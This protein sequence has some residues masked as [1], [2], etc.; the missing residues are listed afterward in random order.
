MMARP[1]RELPEPHGA[2]L[3][4]HS[5]L[6]DRDPELLEDPAHQIDKAPT[7]D[8]VDGRNR[9]VIDHLAQL[10]ALRVVEKRTVPWRLAVQQPGGPIPVEPHHPVPHRLQPDTADLRGLGP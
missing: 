9:P 4:A 5:L 10:I 8:V 3:A 2:Q 6:G 1:G 7:H